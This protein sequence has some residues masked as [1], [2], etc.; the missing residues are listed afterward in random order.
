[1]MHEKK[2]NLVKN[3][4]IENFLVLIDRALIEYQ[5]SQ[6]EARLE[7]SGNFRLIKNYT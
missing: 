3:L 5:S 4:K 7:K 6:P 2:K 1:M